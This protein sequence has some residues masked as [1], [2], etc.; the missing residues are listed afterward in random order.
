VA[1]S[2]FAAEQTDAQSSVAATKTIEVKA[3]LRNGLGM[4]RMT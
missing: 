4:K 2:P 1:V 3:L